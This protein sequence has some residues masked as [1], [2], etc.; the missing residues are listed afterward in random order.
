M[1]K[2]LMQFIL[3]H[4]LLFQGQYGFIRGR[5]TEQAMIEIIYRIT[6]AIE[7]K[8]F[9]LGI[10]LD[11]SK[12]FD[13]IDHNIL[14]KKLH[15]YGIRGTGLTWFRHYLTNRIQYVDTGK[16]E[17]SELPI[18]SGVP[19]G[20]VLG[21]ILFLLY[22]NDMPFLSPIL[23]FIVFADDTTG[24]Y[25]SSSLNELFVTT[26]NELKLLHKWFSSNNLQLNAK[27]TELVLFMTRQKETCTYIDPERHFLI[28]ENINIH[29]STHV[30]FL[31]LQL[32]K[33][34]SYNK[35]IDLVCTKL[36]KGNYALSQ[37]AK[38]L[39]SRELKIIYSAL[40]L[41]YLNYGLLIWGGICKTDTNFTILHKGPTLNHMSTLNKVHKLQKRALRIISKQGFY[42]HHI[43][44]CFSLQLLD[45]EHLYNLKALS[46]FHSYYHGNLPPFFSNKINLYYTR[47]GCLQIK[48]QHR[49]TNIAASNI[50]H[51][52]PNIWNNLPPLLKSE[53]SKSKNTFLSKV[54]SHYL[55][56]YENWKCIHLN[57]YICKKNNKLKK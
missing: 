7:N 49:R 28:L 39:S 13:S 35:H 15:K 30:K 24:I 14:L 1:C 53:I 27:K 17:S 54:K 48:T 6:E 29:P 37:A 16:A 26:E 38:L 42:C 45:L 41:P 36:T 32:D 50:F 51:T 43:P 12:A 46:F 40:I 8:Q 52:L 44:L 31:G 23:N 57:C 5:S 9:S 55:G 19:Q 18:I 56:S 25:N 33:N 11:L 2:R 10:F 3:K 21:P 34:L 4:N 47:D 20:S 22:I